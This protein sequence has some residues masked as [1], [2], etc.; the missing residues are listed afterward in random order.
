MSVAYSILSTVKVVSA[1][2]K[3]ISHHVLNAKHHEKEAMI[4]AQAGRKGAVVIA[5]NM[6]GRGTDI[7]LGGN[8]EYLA[9]EKLAKEKFLSEEEFET[10]LK[11]YYKT[12]ENPKLTASTTKLSNW[13]VC[14]S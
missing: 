14:I 4:V 2:R 1:I 7:L 13:A 10:K 11:E 3:G 8:P 5:T 9:R 12:D 6:A